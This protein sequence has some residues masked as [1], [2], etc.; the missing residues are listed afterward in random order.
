[1]TKHNILKKVAFSILFTLCTIMVYAQEQEQKDPEEM[2]IEQA[3][4]FE[5]SL[6]LLPHQAF[7]IDSI[8][9][10]D[11]VAMSEEIK[12]MQNSGTQEYT[13][14]KQI[15]EKWVAQ[16]DSSFKKVLDDNQWIKYLKLTGKYIKPKKQKLQKR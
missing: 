15:R 6:S 16:I 10:H 11:M 4:E 9:R 3:L 7:F 8:L 12:E 14:Y 1:M 13:L 2:A 5:K